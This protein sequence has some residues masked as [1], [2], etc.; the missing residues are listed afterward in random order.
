MAP[1]MLM[2]GMLKLTMIMLEDFWGGGVE[3]LFLLS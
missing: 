1:F 2:D 3:V